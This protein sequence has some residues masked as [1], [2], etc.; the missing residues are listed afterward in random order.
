MK[1]RIMERREKGK[2]RRNDHLPKLT[3]DIGGYDT[4]EIPGF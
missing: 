1:N 2:K 3:L 4:P